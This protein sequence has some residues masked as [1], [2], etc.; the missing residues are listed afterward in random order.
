MRDSLVKVVEA[1]NNP[2][3][4]SEK[5]WFELLDDSKWMQHLRQELSFLTPAD[6]VTN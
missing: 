3:K 5:K 2:N 6:R 1:L 4:K